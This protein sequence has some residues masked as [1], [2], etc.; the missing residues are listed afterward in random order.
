MCTERKAQEQG[1]SNS[2]T[3]QDEHSN[4][5]EKRKGGGGGGQIKRKAPSDKAAMIQL[6]VLVKGQIAKNTQ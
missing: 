1:D 3:G 6:S 4:L 2:I 5:E